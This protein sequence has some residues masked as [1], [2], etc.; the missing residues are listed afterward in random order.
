MSYRVPAIGARAAVLD[1]AHV[2]LKHCA[3]ET[4][5]SVMRESFWWPNLRMDCIRVVGACLGCKA[6]RS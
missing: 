6:E 5:Y 1:A 3:A 2:A 4:L